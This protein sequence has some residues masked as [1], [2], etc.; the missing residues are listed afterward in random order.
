MW[1]R[2]LTDLFGPVGSYMMKIRRGAAGLAM[3][4]LTTVGPAMAEYRVDVGD[5]IEIQVAKIPEL[6]RRVTVMQDGRISFPVLGSVSV[7]GLSPSEM[8]SRIQETM[9]TKVF[10]QLSSDGREYAVEID[11]DEV[12][13]NVA[14]HRPLYISG[15]VLRPGE[16]P[17]RPL[18]TV[19]QLVAVAGGYDLLRQRT[20]NPAML[21]ADLRSE[22]QSLWLE[23]AREEAQ[24]LRLKA[25]LGGNDSIETEL[26]TPSPVS[27]LRIAEIV[28][29]ET[30]HLKTENSDH[31]REK[32]FLTRSI[33]QADEQIKILTAQEAME[34]QG[35]RADVEELQ[36]MEEM[37]GRGS[38]PS[39]RVTDARRAMLLS[40][41]RKL[42]TSAQLMEVKKEQ[43]QAARQLERL[44]DQRKIRLLQELQDARVTLDRTQAKLQGTGEKLQHA[45]QKSLLPRDQ[46]LKPNVSI[47]RMGEKNRIV[48]EEDSELQPGDVVEVALRS[49]L[50]MD[51]HAQALTTP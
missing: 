15:D 23:L 50:G 7:A 13:A 27:S 45:G 16:Q 33:K 24:V 31:E 36:K 10:R 25:A 28:G 48:A 41:T 29:V 32:S 4:G 1:R 11:A 30:D 51:V 49:E 38:L 46:E 3:A 40:S 22:Y 8:E 21:A 35:A 20:D 14:Q 6:Q 43:D 47:I 42:Q 12:T 19:R 44:E 34:E 5:V 17:F 2:L 18:M 9:A 39:T 26:L 37:F